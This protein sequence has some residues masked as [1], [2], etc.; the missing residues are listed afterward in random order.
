[1]PADF[2][3]D[4]ERGIVFTKVTGVFG[5]AEV[6]DHMDRLTKHPGFR[7]EFNQLIDFREIS[8]VVLSNEEIRGLARRTIFSSHSHRAYVVASDLQYGLCR[9]FATYRELSGEDGIQIF[10]EMSEALEWLSIPAEPDPKVFTRLESPGDQ[11]A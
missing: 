5:T 9:M 10:R 1:M 6:L 8:R 7:P 4:T 3:I 2:H 11:G